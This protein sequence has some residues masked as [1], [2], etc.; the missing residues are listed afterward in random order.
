M[1]TRDGSL[2]SPAQPCVF[3]DGI[4]VH[5]F[6][7]RICSFGALLSS[8]A[9]SNWSHRRQ[10][11]PSGQASRVPDAAYRAPFAAH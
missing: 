7:L 2:D 6:W 4:R 5:V 9:D 1:S 8:G 11:H 10:S 3:V